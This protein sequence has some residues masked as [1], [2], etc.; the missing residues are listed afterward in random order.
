MKE[1]IVETMET[2]ET[3]EKEKTP[4]KNDDEMK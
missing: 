2:D 1:E 3:D 4:D